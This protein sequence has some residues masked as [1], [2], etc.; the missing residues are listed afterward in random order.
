M[1]G[2]RVCVLLLGVCVIVESAGQEEGRG[3]DGVCAARGRRGACAC[4]RHPVASTCGER[5][6]CSAL[7]ASQSTPST[8]PP[9]SLTVGRADDDAPL[10]LLRPR[11]GAAARCRRDGAR[12]DRWPHGSAARARADG[13]HGCSHCS[14]A[15][16][17]GIGLARAVGRELIASE[18]LSAFVCFFV[19]TSRPRLKRVVDRVRDALVRASIDMVMT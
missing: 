12:R 2:V 10:L 15:H 1:T 7:H 3:A 17:L 8:P 16:A 4:S 18:L 13:L 14:I 19:W 5:T 6:L 11:H 9:L